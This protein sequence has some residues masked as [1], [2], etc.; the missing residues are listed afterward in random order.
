MAEWLKHLLFFQEG[1]YHTFWG[2]IP[3]NGASNWWQKQ[4]E[5]PS[6]HMDL[7][8]FFSNRSGFPY[9]KSTKGWGFALFKAPHFRVMWKT[10]DIHTSQKVLLMVQKTVKPILGCSWGTFTFLTLILGCLDEIQ[11]RSRMSGEVL[12]SF[13]QKNRWWWPKFLFISMP[14][15]PYVRDGFTKGWISIVYN[16]NHTCSFFFENV[17]T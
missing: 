5:K 3:P 12:E 9:Q 6:A 13:D 17:F 11:P 15:F 14:R 4:P 7:Y 8:N 10:V 16:W 1:F 2:K